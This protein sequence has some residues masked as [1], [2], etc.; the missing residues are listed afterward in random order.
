MLVFLHIITGSTVKRKRIVIGKCM[1][2]SLKENI[3]GMYGHCS[4]YK[5]DLIN[6]KWV[7]SGNNT[8]T[9]CRQ[10]YDTAR[11]SHTTITRH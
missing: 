6:C 2:G 10:T 5:D 4:K 3:E 11:K 9:N 7:W 1:P 8:I